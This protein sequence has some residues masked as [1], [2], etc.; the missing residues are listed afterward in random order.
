MNNCKLMERFI[1]KIY[2][3]YNNEKTKENKRKQLNWVVPCIMPLVKGKK[4][5]SVPAQVRILLLMLKK[6]FFW[7]TG[8]SGTHFVSGPELCLVPQ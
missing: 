6:I 2:S 4:T 5:R 3:F 1:I 8:R 7:K